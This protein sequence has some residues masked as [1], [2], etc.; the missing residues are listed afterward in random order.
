MDY[1]IDRIMNRIMEDLDREEDMRDR[2]ISAS[3]R[4]IRLSKNV[5]HSIHTGGDCS[6]HL[7]EM[8]DAIKGLDTRFNVSNDAMMEYA[9]AEIL[10]AIVSRVEFPSPW[11]LGIPYTAW[12][13]GMA[14]AIGELRRFIVTRIIQ[15]DLAVAEEM[16]AC[17]EAMYEALMRVDVPDAILP[18]RRK[19]DIARGILDRTQSD[20]LNASLFH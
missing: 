15:K 19:Q 6:G 11:D 1:G 4:T 8:R 14:D 2:T 12:V 17:M 13:M 5:I 9:E 10:Y 7:K 16:F 20:I 18:I 3:R